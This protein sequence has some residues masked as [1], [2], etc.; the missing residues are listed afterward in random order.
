MVSPVLMALNEHANIRSLAV[1]VDISAESVALEPSPSTTPGYGQEERP[2]V[3]PVR[4]PAARG[5]QAVAP[6]MLGGLPSRTMLRRRRSP[7]FWQ[8]EA[9]QRSTAASRSAPSAIRSARLRV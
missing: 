9:T 5:Q 3:R 4:R 6:V 1:Y 8:S 2:A 7:A